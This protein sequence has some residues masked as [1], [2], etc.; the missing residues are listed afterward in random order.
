MSKLSIDSD[1]CSNA[2][3]RNAKIHSIRLVSDAAMKT[4]FWLSGVMIWKFVSEFSIGIICVSRVNLI[5]RSTFVAVSLR[6]TSRLQDCISQKHVDQNPR[7]E[8]FR[9]SGPLNDWAEAI[10][11][12][13][14]L[15]NVVT[16]CF[17]FAGTFSMTFL[18][19]STPVQKS[20]IY[21]NRCWL[22][23]HV[24]SGCLGNLLIGN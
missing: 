16:F 9:F 3:A 6:L 23:I 2:A 8:T 12:A 14:G 1:V 5:L 7:K 21:L 13:Y 17:W 24:S 11:F 4:I 22:Q 20:R 18:N 15:S 10:R 19:C